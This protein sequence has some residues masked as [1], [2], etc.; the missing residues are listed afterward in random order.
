MHNT[1][2]TVTSLL[3]GATET[4]FA[5]TSD[6]T[7]TD[8]FA[9]TASPQEVAKRGY[10]AM[11]EGELDVVA[12]LTTSQKLTMNML[13][14]QLIRN[15]TKTH[16]VPKEVMTNHKLDNDDYEKFFGVRP[17][18]GT[19][20]ILT[21]SKEDALCPTIYL[22]R[23]SSIILI[24]SFLRKVYYIHVIYSLTVREYKIL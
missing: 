9:K 4:E 20:N 12:G 7:N 13:K 11:L 16:I 6:M 15:A 8:L 21:I 18:I 14:V 5:K 22:A 19:R 2:I 23:S 24:Q 10:N 1:N 3:P 17:K